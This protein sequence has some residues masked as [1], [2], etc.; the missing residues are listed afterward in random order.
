MQ[1]VDDVPC[2]IRHSG[3]NNLDHVST[4]GTREAA[5]TRVSRIRLERVVE[6]ARRGH[7]KHVGG[8]V[9]KERSPTRFSTLGSSFLPCARERF[10]FP[11]HSECSSVLQ[12]GCSTRT[13]ACGHTCSG[14]YR[15][16]WRWSVARSSVA[17]GVFLLL[18]R[19]HAATVFSVVTHSVRAGA[20]TDGRCGW[21]GRAR[22]RDCIEGTRHKTCTSTADR[23]VQ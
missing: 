14:M 4:L 21:S 23:H 22:I 6:R 10:Q 13:E 20:L 19:S 15:G 18:L 9:W 11:L 5:R 17:V 12:W 8:G 7:V 16:G 1:V 2:P 3:A